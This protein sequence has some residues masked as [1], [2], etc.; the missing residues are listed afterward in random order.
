MKARKAVF[1]GS[2]Y[3]AIPSECERQIKAFVKEAKY[4]TLSGIK[5][6]GGIVPHA[7]WYFSG[8]IACNIIKI[9]SEG[10][11][12]DVFLVFGMHLHQGSPCY[13]MKE[14]AWETPFG[15]IKIHEEIAAELS[16]KYPFQIETAQRFTQD[17]TIELQLPFIKYF[18][19][20]VKIV[21]MGVPPVKK[22]FEIGKDA[23]KIATG[24]GLKVMVLG[25]TDLTHYGVNY[26]FVSKGTGA[27]AL[28]W[29]KNENDKKVIDAMLEMNPEKV[30]E[31]ALLNENA[32]CSGAAATAISTAKELGA[33]S[34]K[35]ITYSTSYDISPSD[36][37]VGYAGIVF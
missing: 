17:N 18:F 24:L 35:L 30:I 1:A 25:S 20:D 34:A 16:G 37:F 14:G 21:P 2:W 9:L 28:N 19:K 7:G 5:R 4:E 13:L 27:S 29:V 6:I 32:C 11:K 33:A 3:P 8:S 23:A 10:I 26:G 15:D 31:E 22:S 36:S 12:P